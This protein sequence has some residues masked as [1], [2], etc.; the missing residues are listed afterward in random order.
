MR[1]HHQN[2]QQRQRSCLPPS[3]S[4]LPPTC[5]VRHVHVD[6]P[7]DNFYIHRRISLPVHATSEFPR[8]A[9]RLRMRASTW[10]SFP[11]PTCCFRCFRRHRCR[12][13]AFVPSATIDGPVRAVGFPSKQ[14]KDDDDDL[15]P[16]SSRCPSLDLH[17]PNPPTTKRE[18]ERA[19][20][21]AVGRGGRRGGAVD[22]TNVVESGEGID[23]GRATWQK[24]RGKIDRTQEGCGRV[25][26]LGTCERRCRSNRCI[27]RCS[28]SSA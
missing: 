12:F 14:L 10:T 2:Q 21:R 18:D 23:D 22:R 28:G 27:R 25:L 13:V 3:S 26:P 17:A 15:H 6:A 1:S 4:F 16:P 24:R 9:L 20:P 7:R 19:I 5:A 11:S 8:F